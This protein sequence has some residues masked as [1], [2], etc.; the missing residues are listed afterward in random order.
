MFTTGVVTQTTYSGGFSNLYALKDDTYY[1]AG[2]DKIHGC[3]FFGQ[4]KLI[5]AYETVK[6]VVADITSGTGATG[7]LGA[8]T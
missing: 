4:N 7:G 8:F 3:D 1:E 6:I 2:G 5:C